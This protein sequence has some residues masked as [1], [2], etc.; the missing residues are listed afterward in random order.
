VTSQHTFR[1]ET[2]P[3]R[4]AQGHWRQ[5]AD[6]LIAEPG[7]WALVLTKA[8]RN[9]SGNVR[10]ALHRYGGAFQAAERRQPDG[11][12]NIYARYIDGLDPTDPRLAIQAEASAS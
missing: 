7:R 12:L 3:P 11:T 6:Q 10:V 5:I 8:S 4:A 1:W 9:G 2:P